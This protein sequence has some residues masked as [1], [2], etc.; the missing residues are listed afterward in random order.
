MGEE[1]EVYLDAARMF[2]DLVRRIEPDAW[3][4][5]GLGGWDLRA[6]VGHTSRS[7]VTVLT[8]IEQPA[9]TEAI[10][11]ARDYYALIAG[12][13]LDST[14]I[15]TRGRQAGEQLGADPA[16]AIDGLIEQVTA[17]LDGVDGD[18]LITTIGGGM[19]IAAYMPTRTFELAVHCLDIAAA[20]GL[21]LDMPETVL[22][23]A[24]GLATSI[25]VAL[26][27]GQT[28]LTALTGRRDLPPGFSVTI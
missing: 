13:S 14:D 5:P 1:T 28:L 23:D 9:E 24:T 18:L 12:L 19:R 16:S 4:G 21:E 11:S 17:R 2:A 25:A 15:L 6:L 7:L 10:A 3:D 26:G 22:A 27:K 20:T 8:Y